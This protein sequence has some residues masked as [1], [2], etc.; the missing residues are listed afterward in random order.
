LVR[1][2]RELIAP[3]DSH[4]LLDRLYG[5]LRDLLASTSSHVF[6]FDPSSD[7]FTVRAS[8]GERTRE[9]GAAAPL[10][11]PRPS[12]PPVLERLAGDEV[13][14]VDGTDGDDSVLPE[15]LRAGFGAT[16]SLVA[17]LRHGSDVFGIVAV[18]YEDDVH[19]VPDTRV[20]ILHGVGRMASLALENARLADELARANRVKS[21]FV[22]T[23]SHELRTPLNVIIGFTDLLLEDEFGRL[24]EEQADVLRRVDRSAHELLDLINATLDL[25]RLEAGQLPIDVGDVSISTLLQDLRRETTPL[26]AG[27]PDLRLDWLIA[28]DLPTIRSDALKVRVVLKNLLINALKFTE[29][30]RIVVR[31]R[32]SPGGVEVSIT[33]TGIGIPSES[34]QVIFEPFR[35]GAA[36][37]STGIGLGLYIVR[38]LLAELGGTIEVQSEP[39]SG[40]TFRVCLPRTF[41][42]SSE[43]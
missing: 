29:R 42:R 4:V 18:C 22:A 36:T 15:L 43:R 31:A 28:P 24:S 10:S 7:S 35:S 16:Y 23:M 11:L 6:L 30:G 38:R 1:A 17:G 19:R 21:E 14:L 5:L 27:K 32:A 12:L 41:D 3:L 25:S 13:I 34:M 20:R 33:D 2:G 8:G 9:S 40:S 37:T 39:G 26:R